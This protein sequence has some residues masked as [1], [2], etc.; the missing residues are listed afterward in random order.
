MDPVQEDLKIVENALKKNPRLLNAELKAKLEDVR[1]N[2]SIIMEDGSGGVHN[3]DYALE[4]MALAK[5]DLV[6]IKKAIR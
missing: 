4:I 5:R 3:L 6:K 1:A 2:L